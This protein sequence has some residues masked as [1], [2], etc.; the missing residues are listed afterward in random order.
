MGKASAL[1]NKSGRPKSAE[2]IKEVLGCSLRL[3]CVTRWNSL[4]DAIV[5]LLK[6][7]DKL[8]ETLQRLSLPIFRP[9]ELDFLSEYVTVLKPIA[10]ALD[11]LQGEEVAFYG[12]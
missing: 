9:N 12:K 7:R 3:P 11:R 1:W 6:H 8:N 10:C 4:Y 2:V 5:L